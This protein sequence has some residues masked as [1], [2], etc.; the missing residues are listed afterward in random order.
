[1]MQLH[2]GCRNLCS[3]SPDN[4][5]IDTRREKRPQSEHCQSSGQWHTHLQCLLFG[6]CKNDVLCSTFSDTDMPGPFK[7]IE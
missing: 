4:F 7:H 6:P 3:F 2:L 5:D 1:M